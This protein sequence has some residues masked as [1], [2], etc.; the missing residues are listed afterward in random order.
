VAYAAQVGD[1]MVVVVDGE[2]GKQYD[3]IVTTG[4]GRIIFGNR[5]GGLTQYWCGS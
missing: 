4:G 3:G 1:K 5:S 2:E